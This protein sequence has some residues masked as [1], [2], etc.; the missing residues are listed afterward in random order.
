MMK[1]VSYSLL[2]FTFIFLFSLKK[3][4][5]V[6]RVPAQANETENL[7][8]STL[9]W[10][11]T[12]EDEF[13][14]ASTA[15]AKGADPTCFTKKAKCLDRLGWNTQ[16][17]AQE[18]QT[19]L[20]DM[21]KCNWRVYNYYNYMDFDAPEGGGINS[22]HPSKVKIENGKMILSADRSPIPL[23]QIDCKRK[24]LDPT[25]YDTYSTDCAIYSGGVESNE[26]D[27][28]TGKKFG[29]TQAYGRF[30]VYAK[31]SKGQGTWPAFWLL[32]SKGERDDLPYGTKG[33]CG[34]PH[35]GEFDIL[36]SWSDDF[37]HVKS[38][39]IAGYCDDNADVRKGFPRDVSKATSEYHL[40]GVEWT[41]NYIRFIQDNEVMGYVYKDEKV[42]SQNRD[43]GKY[44]FD[45]R[46]WIPSYPF[47]W[48]LNLS[49]ERG[50]GGKKVKVDPDTFYH[51]EL[52][53]ESVRTYRACT[54]EDMKADCIQLKMKD[55]NGVDGYNS[56]KHETAFAEINAYPNPVSRKADDN[57]ITVRLQLKQYCQDVKID[58]INMLGQQMAINSEEANNAQYL[59]NGPLEP[60]TDLYKK[61]Y[62]YHLSAGVYLIRAEYRKCGDYQKGE[63]NQVFKMLVL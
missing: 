62:T 40:Y 5:E 6:S 25:G 35:S 49:I 60:Y 8:Y 9:G 20:K 27:E 11:K 53:I 10:Y 26:W 18:Y 29:F 61:M 30:E 43:T 32:P 39:Y 4:N 59:Y 1:I 13:D 15:I 48:I 21:N 44:G 7:D 46:A 12:F 3:E 2:I 52:V 16:D 55:K 14:P 54:P 42:K 23:S 45:R 57:S 47:Y 28:W 36:E 56:Q 31:L 34:W 37:D 58:V 63:G 51:Q 33:H 41:P 17:C 50:L 22:F 24:Y 19:Q 38:G